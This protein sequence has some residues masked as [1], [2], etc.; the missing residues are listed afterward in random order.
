MLS[1]I[2]ALGFFLIHVDQFGNGM[3]AFVM[4][5]SVKL[6]ELLSLPLVVVMRKLVFC[7]EF[8]TQWN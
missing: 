5:F 4:V 3:H 1:V 6:L 8:A 2:V 7:L